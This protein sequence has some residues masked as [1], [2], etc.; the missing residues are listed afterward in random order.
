MKKASIEL[1]ESVDVDFK[2]KIS[3]YTEIQLNKEV[4]K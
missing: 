1:F 4:L 2:G 3:P